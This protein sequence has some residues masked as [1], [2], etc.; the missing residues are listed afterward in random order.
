M[1]IPTMVCI[2]FCFIGY[3]FFLQDLRRDKLEARL[4]EKIKE[5]ENKI[6]TTRSGQKPGQN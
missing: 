6:D 2:A 1:N 3:F 5:L 4:L